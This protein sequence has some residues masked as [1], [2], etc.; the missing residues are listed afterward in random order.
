[1]AAKWIKTK[2]PTFEQSSRRVFQI[3]RKR[4]TGRPNDPGDH[5]FIGTMQPQAAEFSPATPENSA[6]FC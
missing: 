3:D 2:C 4:R 5:P 6:A 1:M